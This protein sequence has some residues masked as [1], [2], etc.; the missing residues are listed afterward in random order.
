LPKVSHQPKRL[1]LIGTQQRTNSHNRKSN[2]EQ[3]GCSS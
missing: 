3:W 2:P 1:Q